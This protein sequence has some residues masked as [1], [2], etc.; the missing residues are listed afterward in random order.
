M[1]Q[2]FF[3]S[4]E[5]TLRKLKR[6][7]LKMKNQEKIQE[8]QILEQTIQNLLFQ[9]QTFQMEFAETKSALSEL[10]KSSDDVF[11]IIG[12]LMIKTEKSKTKKELEDKLK[13]TE[14][15]LKTLDKQEISMTSQIGKIRQE[16]MG[17]EE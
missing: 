9:K 2:R 16:L 11:K 6:F 1:A 7:N 13:I 3:S 10:E 14:L 15:R 12:Q 8:L 17:S 4:Q 5:L